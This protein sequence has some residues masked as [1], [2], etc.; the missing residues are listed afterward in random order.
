MEAK[1]KIDQEAPDEIPDWEDPGE[2]DFDF[3]KPT[4]K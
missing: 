2:E 3:S 4:L 1:L